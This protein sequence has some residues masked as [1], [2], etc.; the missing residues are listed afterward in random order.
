MSLVTGFLEKG[1]VP[2]GLIRVGIR[3]RLS[4]KLWAESDGGSAA[5][6]K[7]KNEILE[8]IQQSPISIFTESANEQHYELPAAFFEKVLGEHLKYSSG[9]W[10]EG[11]GELDQSEE[12]MLALT[13]KR[14]DIQDGQEILELGCGW[15]SL[16]LYMAKR[17]S[18][19]RITVVSNSHSQKKYIDHVA[20]ERRLGNLTVITAEMGSLALPQVFDRVVSV[21][22]F[23]HMRSYPKLFEKVARFM[24]P[25]A[26][27]FIH[28]FAHQKYAYFYEEQDPDDWIARYFFTG[29][30]MPSADLF[31]YF[32]NHLAI[33]TQWQVS[34]T[35]YQ[36]TCRAWLRRMDR[37]KAEILPILQ[38]VYGS[39]YK[40]WWNYWRV[41][42]MACEELF[43][44][45][46]GKEWMVCHYLLEKR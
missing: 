45:R 29:G 12:D 20:S 23:E 2:D 19:S 8:K 11:V 34:G 16:S 33:K 6:E 44:Y 43:A 31:S 4:K 13:V 9:F 46:G 15:G 32:Q 41:F 10:K 38:G 22:M 5:E 26:K 37:K 18:K 30:T 25:E 17:F 24:K 14:A 7:R 40:K 3:A 35:H 28:V 39:E 27:L 42:F 1:L 36:K 21:E